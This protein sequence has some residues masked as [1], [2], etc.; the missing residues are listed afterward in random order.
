MAMSP[1]DLVNDQMVTLQED[2]H[3]DSAMNS[4]T[5]DWLDVDAPKVN[6]DCFKSENHSMKS[7]LFIDDQWFV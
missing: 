3:D 6:I 5:Q 4:V 1:G 2:E 7:V